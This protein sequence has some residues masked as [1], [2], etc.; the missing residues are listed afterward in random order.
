MPADGLPTK[1]PPH[2][3]QA[4]RAVLASVLLDAETCWWLLIDRVSEPEFYDPRHALLWD[5]FATIIARREHLDVLTVVAELRAR[6]RLNTVGGA[7]YVGELTDEIP[8]LAHC[9]SHARI[10]RHLA[11]VRRIIEAAQE[12]VALGWEH[13]DADAYAEQALAKLSKATEGA[14]GDAES[15]RLADAVA[16]ALSD[17]E[18]AVGAPTA[19]WL[20]PQLEYV[21]G[22]LKPG[23]LLILGARPGVGKTAHMLETVIQAASDG[24]V[25]VAS[26]EAPRVEVAQRMIARVSGVELNRWMRKADRARLAEEDADAFEAVEAAGNDLSR[27]DVTFADAGRQTVASIFARARKLK[28]QA[29]AEGRKLALVAIDYLQLLQAPRDLGREATREQAVGGNARALKLMAMELGVPV[30]ALSQLNRDAENEEP[31]LGMLRESGSLEQD[32]N[33]VLFLH[34]EKDQDRAAPVKR[35]S[36]L[37]A[38]QRNGIADVSIELTY[39]RATMAFAEVE[40]TERQEFAPRRPPRGR[41]RRGERA[42]APPQAPDDERGGDF[43]DRYGTEGLPVETRAEFPGEN[44][45]LDQGDAW[46]GR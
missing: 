13:G 16:L 17:D 12:I 9:E 41:G 5:V 39:T 29:E 15:C 4:E 14:G 37:V 6:D 35:V 19:H 3:L 24:A 46:G 45:R 11:R 28:A 20:H 2:D 36:L 27:R 23:Q 42:P 44:G 21:T 18:E 30:L 31:T 38:K 32:A 26:M 1:A 10:V 33:V 40:A 7:Q 43:L 8:T 25:L 22:G 34:P